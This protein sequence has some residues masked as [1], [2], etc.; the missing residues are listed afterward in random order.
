MFSYPSFH[1]IFCQIKCF[2]VGFDKLSVRYWSVKRTMKQRQLK[3]WSNTC[4]KEECQFFFLRNTMHLR[5]T[6]NKRLALGWREENNSRKN[7]HEA[8]ENSGDANHT[9]QTKPLATHATGSQSLSYRISVSF[10]SFM[11]YCW[12]SSC[13]NALPSL[14]HFLA[15][16]NLGEKGKIV[17]RL[18]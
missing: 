6:Y 12:K 10:S 11:R 4:I 9:Q 8:R 16:A 13:I 18:S 5:Y 14:L 17:S 3:S 2:H 15:L 1:F 7:A